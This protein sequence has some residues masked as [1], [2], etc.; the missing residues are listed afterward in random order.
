MSEKFQST[1]VASVPRQIF[2]AYDIRG[3][4][5]QLSD[6]LVAQIG[7]ALATQ[8]IRDNQRQVVIGYDARLSSCEF[9]EIITEQLTASG[10]DVVQ[11]G[12]V[13]SPLLY[14]TAKRFAGNGIMITASHNP[15]SDNGF[16]WLC[17]H[18]PPTAEQIQDIANLIE[19]Q[20]F[21]TLPRRG[22]VTTIDAK[23][24][25]FAYL[26]ADIKL[27]KKY[28]VCIEGLHGSAGEIAKIALENLGCEV[29]AL[30]CYA[31]GNF[32][33]GAPDPSDVKRLTTLQQ[34]V[35]DSKSV[36]GFALDGDGDRLVVI[37]ERGQW[38]SPDRL[39]CILAKICLTDQR[40]HASAEIV[41]DVKCSTMIA[42]TIEKYHGRS[43]MLRTGSSFLRHYIAAQ[44]AL[45]GGEYAGHYVFNDGRGLGY[46]DGLYGA[47][48][49]LEYLE[50][51]Q[52]SLSELLAEFPERIASPD[53]YIDA[54]GI[55][56]VQLFA[57]IEHYLN[58]LHHKD[59]HAMK[60]SCIDGIRLDFPYGFGLIRASNTGEYFT[61]RI[62]AD[63]AEHF[64]KIKAFFVKMVHTI[65]PQFSQALQAIVA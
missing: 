29:I 5:A 20:D 41:F 52:H 56:R 19:S 18:L 54:G 57:H 43:H 38:I 12:C 27:Q 3:K 65:S 42:Q 24:E 64:A 59:D 37:D 2:R 46:D 33:H 49:L 58:D 62:D 55:D 35:L 45:F 4:V 8:F 32:P 10:L 23:A 13:S 39:M 21:Q 16:K 1:T 7:K 51:T 11:I 47:L 26:K 14:F 36:M 44:S 34:A 17:R 9:S 48:R 31:D 50:S 53:I 6:G 22:K 15:T 30:N 63:D 60:L 28:R 61:V 25:Y 40:I